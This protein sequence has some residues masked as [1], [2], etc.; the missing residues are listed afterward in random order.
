MAG[1]VIIE[2]HEMF[3]KAKTK[4]FVN[5]KEH[6]V[7]LGCEK[8]T[9][10]ID[11]DVQIGAK[12]FINPKNNEVTARNNEVTK[13]LITKLK[14]KMVTEIVS[15]TS[16]DSFVEEVEDKPI[17]DLE[18]ARG[19]Q[20]KVY[21]DKCVIKVKANLISF[22]TGNGSDGEKTIYYSDVLGVQYKR[23]GLQLG[24]LQLETASSSMNNKSDNF[25]NENSFTFDANLDG[26]MEEVQKFVKQKV[27]EAKKQKNAP[28][29]VA[30]SVSNADELKKYKELLDMGVISQEEFDAKKKQLL[31]L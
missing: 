29:M 2:A 4:I 27:D 31:G 17:Y 25:F 13:L 9:I 26:I 5:G 20:L 11:A 28:I 12:V 14:G 23:T 3:G 7:I 6:C 1:K 10:D 21:E 15:I 8:A 30:A 24:Y 22:A 19:R 18:G 16:L